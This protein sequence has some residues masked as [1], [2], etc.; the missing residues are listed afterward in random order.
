MTAKNKRTR[1]PNPHPGLGNKTNP[2]HNP[3]PFAWLERHEMAW[4]TVSSACPPASRPAQPP[5]SILYTQMVGP[6]L[7]PPKE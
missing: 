7:V 3:G 6:V 1:S 5:T 4:K 2:G